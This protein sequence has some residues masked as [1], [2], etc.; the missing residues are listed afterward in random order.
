MPCIS[1]VWE[2]AAARRASTSQPL[3][4]SGRPPFAGLPPVNR[5]LYRGRFTLTFGSVFL[6]NMREHAQ[7]EPRG[8]R[9]AQFLWP[10][11]F[12]F[13]PR[14]GAADCDLAQPNSC[15]RPYVCGYK[16]VGGKPGIQP[17]ALCSQNPPAIAWLVRST[18]PI[19]AEAMRLAVCAR[20]RR[21][22]EGLGADRVQ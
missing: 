20:S 7:T 22:R 16:E 4:G 10:V 13:F 17:S 18:V 8:E 5:P 6:G 2:E 19:I 3:A 9:C 14:E 1:S 21:S 11:Q 15:E 12:D